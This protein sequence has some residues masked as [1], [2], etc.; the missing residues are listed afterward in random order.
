MWVCVCARTCACP[1][2]A[3][4]GPVYTAACFVFF[5]LNFL[6]PGFHLK[7]LQILFGTKLDLRNASPKL[8]YLE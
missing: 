6:I 4:M 3:G 8:H 5:F 7:L 2:Q 1:S